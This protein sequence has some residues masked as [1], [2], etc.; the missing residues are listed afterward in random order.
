[1]PETAAH[2]RIPPE[3][4]SPST[5]TSSSL[6]QV[7]HHLRL[8][9]AE[10]TLGLLFLHE[11]GIVHQDIKPANVRISS[12]GHAVISDLGAASRLPLRSST[13]L[14]SDLSCSP[15]EY[16]PIVLQLDDSV[17][18]TPLYAAPELRQRNHMGL[19]IYDERVD[20]W[21]LGILIHE[22]V[23]GA[24]PFL[25][26]PNSEKS[27]SLD[28]LEQPDERSPHLESLLRSVSSIWF[29]QNKSVK[30]GVASYPRS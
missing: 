6:D 16:G 30:L 29:A 20:W 23:S 10:I 5:Y 13:L 11:N 21:S 9:V 18:F 17:T 26:L 25:P 22:L 8:L 14:A 1:M 12:G 19:V 4:S 27:L 3:F 2:F 28:T 7:L 24:T 15:N